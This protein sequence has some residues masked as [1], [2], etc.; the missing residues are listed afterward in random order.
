MPA[1]K[2]MVAD[3]KAEEIKDSET[4]EK[5]EVAT[6][7][8]EG[9][10]DRVSAEEIADAAV[11]RASK[12]GSDVR[13]WADLSEH[14]IATILANPTQYQNYIPGAIAEN[15]RRVEASVMSKVEMAMDVKSASLN[16]PDA[17]DPKTLLGKEVQK[18]VTRKTHGQ[19]L[20]D[21]I[22][23]ATYRLGK[24]KVDQTNRRKIVDNIKAASMI[25][26][27][28]T[29][30]GEQKPISPKEMTSKDFNEMVKRTKLR[31]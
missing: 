8:D 29:T 13:Q 14:E 3:E 27:G 4:T 1:E 22:E 25:V 10:V 2:E 18:I 31:T 5:E 9:M 20:S 23:L 7:D 15:N 12:T 28:S 6:S 21:A 16:S 11:K 19:I 26:G 17:F 30:E 24:G